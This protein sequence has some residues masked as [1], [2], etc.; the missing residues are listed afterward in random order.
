M[1]SEM[2]PDTNDVYHHTEKRNGAF[3]LKSAIQRVN[4]ALHSTDSQK[5]GA[6]AQAPML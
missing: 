2:N 5:K 1:A 6:I 4:E 3:S